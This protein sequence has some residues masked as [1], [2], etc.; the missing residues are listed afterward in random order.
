MVRAAVLLLAGLILPGSSDT[1]AQE[2]AIAMDT[3]E[4]LLE[5]CEQAEHGQP[6]RALKLAD[7][8]RPT[9]HANG[10]TAPPTCTSAI[11]SITP[12]NMQRC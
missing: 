3:I 12:P 6:E 8:N 5:G 4:Q 7:E 10:F 1:A 11:T 2:T 9:R